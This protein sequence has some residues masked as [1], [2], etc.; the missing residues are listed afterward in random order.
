MGGIT[1]SKGLFCFG[2]EAY[3]WDGEPIYK[4]NESVGFHRMWF[5]DGISQESD[6]DVALQSRE[7]YWTKRC[8][9]DKLEHDKKLHAYTIHRTLLNNELV[10]DF[11]AKEYIDNVKNFKKIYPLMH[12]LGYVPY[13]YYSGNKGLHVH[14]FISYK[15]L[16]QELDMDL[17]LRIRRKYANKETFIKQLTKYLAT[18]VNWLYINYEIDGSLNHKNHLIRTAGSLNKL[19]FKTFLGHT[20]EDIPL[21]APVFNLE[22]RQYPRFPFHH[23][24]YTDSEI[25]YSVPTDLIKICTQFVLENKIGKIESKNKSL[26]DFFKPAPSQS[27]FQ[28]FR[29]CIQFFES[30]DFAD[31]KECRKRVL[32]ILASHHS[33]STDLIGTLRSWN[34]IFLGNYLRDDLIQNTVKSTTGKVGCTYIKEI[35]GSLGK[36]DLC[37][38]CSR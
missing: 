5:L 20:P 24:C 25:K 33:R 16:A 1:M 14:F 4:E 28:K 19:G 3:W 30:Q 6:F 7:G 15:I 13:V 8:P 32:F 34:Q 11:D 9:W 37:K 29:P 18:K 36:T 38:G 23:G 17:Q 26:K 31:M 21:V 27:T 2:E 12:D 35:L 10:F 22:N